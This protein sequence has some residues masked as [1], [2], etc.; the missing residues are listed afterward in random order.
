MLYLRRTTIFYYVTILYCVYG[1]GDTFLYCAVTRIGQITGDLAVR[2]PN[3]LRPGNCPY[4]FVLPVHPTSSVQVT[5]RRLDSLATQ[6]ARSWSL[7]FVFSELVNSSLDL[8][9]LNKVI[10]IGRFP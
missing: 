4:R 6:Q 9:L 1:Q 8:T 2:L 7:F 10:R 5:V 3:K